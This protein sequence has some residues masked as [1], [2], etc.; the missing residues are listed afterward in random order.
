MSIC[1]ITIRDTETGIDI[2]TTEIADPDGA[3]DTQALVLGA[4]MF[5]NATRYLE[6]HH[7]LDQSQSHQRRPLCH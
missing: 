7:Q 2:Q 4:A 3:L 1:I 5:A 6:K